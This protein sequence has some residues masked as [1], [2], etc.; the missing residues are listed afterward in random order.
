ML[1]RKPHILNLDWWNNLAQMF[2]D[3]RLKKLYRS[4]A[5]L[6]SSAPKSGL[7]PWSVSVREHI[8]PIIPVCLRLVSEWFVWWF[9]DPNTTSSPLPCSLLVRS[10]PLPL[11]LSLPLFPL[12]PLPLSFSLPLP[13]P[14]FL[15]FCLLLLFFNLGCP[16]PPSVD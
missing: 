14:L 9:P 1:L 4:L 2:V 16:G 7:H 10:R 3:F 12:L 6:Y 5:G 11:P 13:P 8:Q 15:S